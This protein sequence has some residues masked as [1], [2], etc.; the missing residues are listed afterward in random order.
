MAVLLQGLR[1]EDIQELLYVSTRS[2]RRF[3]ALFDES[4]DVGP[5]IQ[6]HSP[7]RTFHAFEEISL[8]Q[9]LLS[10]PDMYL[11]ELRQELIQIAGTDVSLSTIC[12]TLKWL[13]FSR[14]KLRHIPCREV[15]KRG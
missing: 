12:R 9:S 2:V 5:A 7:C 6:Q 13:G 15:R 1:F 10:K 8:I 3:I 14:K 4:D 11:E